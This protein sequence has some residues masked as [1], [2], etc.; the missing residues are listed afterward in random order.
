M[1]A[2][3]AATLALV[4]ALQALLALVFV[5]SFFPTH[6]TVDLIYPV[7]ADFQHPV[8]ALF[9]YRLFIVL[10]VCFY[11]AFLYVLKHKAAFFKDLGRVRKIA[12][13]EGLVLALMLTAF[14]GHTMYG[15]APFQ[16]AFIFSLI[17]AA[18]AKI[19]WPWMDRFRWD[20][21]G[22]KW[23][24]DVVFMLLIALLIF[25]PD[26]SALVAKV[27]LSGQGQRQNNC[28]I[29]G[30]GYVSL[31][32]GVP[33]V[34]VLSWYGMGAPVILSKLAHFFGGFS[35]ERVAQVAVFLLILYF[36]AWYFLLRRWFAGA[37]WAAA[38]VLFMINVRVWGPEGEPVNLFMSLNAT[39]LRYLFD[40]VFFSC[41]SVHLYTRRL[42]W[43]LAA[44]AAAGVQV[45]H[46]TSTGF[47]LTVVFYTYLLMLAL[48]P[49]CRAYYVK[50]VTAWKIWACGW[51]APVA[52]FLLCV[53]LC[54]GRQAATP[55]FWHNF[56][57][58]YR[59]S[60]SGLWLS[61]YTNVLADPSALFWSL[62][63]LALYGVSLIAPLTLLSSRQQ[64]DQRLMLIA[65]FAVYGLLDY[66]YFIMIASGVVL[67][68]NAT[69]CIVLLWLWTDVILSGRPHLNRF[70]WQA[71]ALLLA[72]CCTAL[73]PHFLNY[74]NALNLSK[75]P[76]T[77]SLVPA[78]SGQGM[79][80]SVDLNYP[81][82]LKLPVNS[83]GQV[84]EDLRTDKDFMSDSQ[85]R[86]YVRQEY[87][88]SQDAALIRSLTSADDKV[89]LLSSQEIPI[90]M[91]AKRKPFFYVFPLLVSRSMRARTFPENEL[92]TQE[93]LSK[94]IEQ[95]ASLRPQYV[96]VQKVLL[97]KHLP[98]SYYFQYSGII[99]IMQYLWQNYV[100]YQEGKYLVALKR[101]T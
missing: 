31:N 48:L 45:F 38:A 58:Q 22:R 76:V 91:Q 100:P 4:Q 19:A 81:A 24:F 28:F 71:A 68:R 54:A 18:A 11:A 21:S 39:P 34:D 72:L 77:D 46:N 20:I 7:A 64:I 33:Y 67:F 52:S 6:L 35:Y 66:Q 15:A 37:A 78:A 30:P 96:F 5:F 90:L 85:L 41:I 95:L 55:E 23:V 63:L 32:G 82:Q 75:N 8:R 1:I 65:L 69:I 59:Y 12:A 80:N 42:G 89:A 93:N 98:Q 14:L 97:T 43:L 29:M 40:V 17:I 86:E 74:P 84:D 60:N 27:S 56:F 44:G 3:W 47:C 61:S 92:Y 57:I 10:F 88:F 73:N 25:I 53:F 2:V 87:D 70:P 83:V 99:Q 16:K 94:T 79:I 50:T 26:V 62:A 49:S 9:F 13:L 51:A 101:K 36:G